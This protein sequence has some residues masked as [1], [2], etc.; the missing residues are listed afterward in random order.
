MKISQ[1]L[2]EKCGR[3]IMGAT[4]MNIDE[5]L[6]RMAARR[7]HAERVGKTF[8]SETSPVRMLS[9]AKRGNTGKTV[10]QD[11]VDK[12]FA[13]TLENEI[14]RAKASVKRFAS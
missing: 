14:E 10:A 8:A 4:T 5:V 13:A 12:V 1:N 2:V 6:E 7:P 9:E 3:L 11:D